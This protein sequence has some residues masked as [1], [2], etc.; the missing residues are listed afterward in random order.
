MGGEMP[1][2]YHRDY[3][4]KNLAAT[5]LWTEK[6]RDT[7]KAS[8]KPELRDIYWAAGFLEGEGSFRQFNKTGNSCG[9]EATNCDLQPLYKLQRLFG[10]RISKKT[11]GPR[12]KQQPYAW[13]AFGV[14]ARGII[15]TVYTMMSDKRKGQCRAA[16]KA[17]EKE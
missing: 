13:R 5:P 11:M 1:K 7:P 10:G 17:G 2:E 12:N 15:L 4:R 9:V 8:M 16:L 6:H 14:R 3:Y